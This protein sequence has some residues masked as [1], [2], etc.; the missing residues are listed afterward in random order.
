MT[1]ELRR[2]IGTFETAKQAERTLTRLRRAQIDPQQVRI[3]SLQEEPEAQPVEKPAPTDGR[4]F[5]AE[6]V[7]DGA[8]KGAALGGL[9]GTLGG[10][11][12]GLGAM[13]VPG[14]GLV[15][16]TGALGAAV[17]G[18]LAGGSVGA[19]AGGLVG[20]LIGL[21]IPEADARTYCEHVRQG[22]TLLLVE[23]TPEAMAQIE[24]ILNE[25]GVDHFRIYRLEDRAGVGPS[26]PTV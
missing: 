19:V 5:L 18:A 25:G 8:V 9:V 11:A 15:L 20:S 13:V 6:H 22:R 23:G 21:G 7:S 24:P 17:A 4:T 2:A 14:A 3:F 26:S 12:F 10:L 1:T 16:A